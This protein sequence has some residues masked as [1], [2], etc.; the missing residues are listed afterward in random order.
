MLTKNVFITVTN[1]FSSVISRLLYSKI[2]FFEF[3]PF[4]L[5]QS[6][7]VFNFFVFDRSFAFGFWKY[8]TS[9][10]RSRLPQ[11]FLC[12]LQF[13]QLSSVLHFLK[14]F[15]NFDLCI[16]AFRKAFD[17]KELLLKQSISFIGA[18]LSRSFKKTF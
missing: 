15:F 18:G 11:K 1:S 4:L 17:I 5:K 8:S 2:N 7:L 3:K 6:F 12:L 9:V 13:D 14:I 10:L 16:I